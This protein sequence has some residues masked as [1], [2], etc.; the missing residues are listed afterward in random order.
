M[1][2]LI[3]RIAILLALVLVILSSLVLILEYTQET[4]DSNDRSTLEVLS[5]R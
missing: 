1:K 5:L 2:K 3:I 4:R